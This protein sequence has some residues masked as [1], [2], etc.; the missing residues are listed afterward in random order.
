LGGKVYSPLIEKGRADLLV[1]FAA[2]ERRRHSGYLRKGGVL[3]EA[4][5][6]MREKLPN[7]RTVNV[8][9]VGILSAHLD[10]PLSVWSD[11]IAAN[12]P[13]KSL[14]D[15]KR[16]FL[17]GREIGSGNHDLGRRA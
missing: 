3:V 1:S 8:A 16:A 9:V 17:I 15:N 2:E 6:G 10:I 13:E 4:P 7:P 14:E 5:P 12:V 11:A